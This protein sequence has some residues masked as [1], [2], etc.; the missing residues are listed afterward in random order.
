MFTKESRMKLYNLQTIIQHGTF[1]KLHLD[2]KVL[3]FSAFLL[4]SVSSW[5]KILLT[6]C[7]YWTDAWLM[8]RL[9]CN[10]SSNI[11]QYAVLLLFNTNCRIFLH[12]CLHLF[13]LN[14]HTFIH[15]YTNFKKSCYFQNYSNIL[16]FICDF[17]VKYKW[18]VFDIKN[19]VLCMYV[20]IIDV[21]F[22][23]NKLTR[24]YYYYYVTNFNYY[25]IWR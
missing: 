23:A 7:K 5:H 8:C 13:W 17:V 11:W 24:Y 10:N 3:W 21:T 20:I 4:I 25:N 22:M 12:K 14:N 9:D 15:F 16:Y 18:N 1:N 19:Y 6:L 2:T